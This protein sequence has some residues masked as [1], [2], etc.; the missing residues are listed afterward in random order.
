[1]IEY[2][3][4]L[5]YNNFNELKTNKNELIINLPLIKP[6]SY[7]KLEAYISQVENFCKNYCNGLNNKA[8]EKLEK[9][10]KLNRNNFETNEEYNETI[11]SMY[12]EFINYLETLYPK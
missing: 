2:F 4:L 11:T 6:S 10:Y 9:I 3:N 5:Q 12:L 8:K 1:M 7:T